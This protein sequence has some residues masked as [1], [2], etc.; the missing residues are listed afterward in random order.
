MDYKFSNFPAKIVLLFHP[1]FQKQL[2]PLFSGSKSADS[3]NGATGISA[4]P[5]V[6]KRWSC[7]SL[8]Y[9]EFESDIPNEQ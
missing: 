6:G 5:A 8:R 4:N 7:F 2:N 9:Q 3:E 1:S